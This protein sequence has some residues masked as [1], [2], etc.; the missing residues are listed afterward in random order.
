MIYITETFNTSDPGTVEHMVAE[1]IEALTSD[2]SE[3]SYFS[4]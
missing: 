2:Q 1:M 4:Q 3:C